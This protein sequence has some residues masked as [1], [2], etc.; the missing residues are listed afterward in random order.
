MARWEDYEGVSCLSCHREVF[1]VLEG[2]CLRCW[3]A[4]GEEYQGLL[5]VEQTLKQAQKRYPGMVSL[6][7]LRRAK[8][9]LTRRA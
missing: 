6:K 3:R 9:R 7:S 8:A 2:R 4:D 5:E 1:Q